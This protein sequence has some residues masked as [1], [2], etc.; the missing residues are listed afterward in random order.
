MT[1]GEKIKITRNELGLTQQELAEQLNVYRSAVSNWESG[2]NY[3]DLKM[4]VKLSDT[5]D[6]SLKK[7][8]R[9][10]ERMVKVISK[11]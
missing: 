11:V 6:I 7:L 2:R 3:P 9:E 10:D 8:L 5:L 1:I 4:I